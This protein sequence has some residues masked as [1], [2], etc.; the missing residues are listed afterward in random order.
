MQAKCGLPQRIK[1]NDGLRHRVRE[2]AI[3]G[4]LKL[5]HLRSPVNQ[6]GSRMKEMI[7]ELVVRFAYN[8]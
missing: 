2:R 5:E 6:E 1:N 8:R 4:I 7:V 3:L